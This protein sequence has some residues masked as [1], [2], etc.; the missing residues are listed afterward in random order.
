MVLNKTKLS[1]LAN[2]PWVSQILRMLPSS[3][4]AHPPECTILSSLW[5]FDIRIQFV[6]YIRN[7][8]IYLHKL[9]AVCVPVYVPVCVCVLTWQL[10]DKG[11]F[12]KLLPRGQWE[13]LYSSI[14][15]LAIHVYHYCIHNR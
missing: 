10:K 5:L 6:E 13:A 15:M 11:R 2:V 7:E 8:Q 9:Q 1:P 14:E 12:L 4:I 3:T